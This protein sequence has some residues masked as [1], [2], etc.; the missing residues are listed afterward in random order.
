MCPLIVAKQLCIP[1][2]TFAPTWSVHEELANDKL[3]FIPKSRKGNQVEEEKTKHSEKKKKK[4]ECMATVVQ[5]VEV[6]KDI[7]WEAWNDRLIS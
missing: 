3:I 1:F 7:K 2:A 6:A 5:V 4:Q